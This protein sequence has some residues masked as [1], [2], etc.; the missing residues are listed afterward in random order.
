MLMVQLDWPW[1]S[2]QVHFAWSHLYPR[3]TLGLSGFLS[4]NVSYDSSIK[5]IDFKFGLTLLNL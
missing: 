4:Y 5:S 1:S 2:R 3:G